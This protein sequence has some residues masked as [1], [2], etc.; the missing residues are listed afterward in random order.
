MRPNSVPAGR[1]LAKAGAAPK[2]SAVRSTAPSAT[3][4]SASSWSSVNKADAVAPTQ[5]R[6]NTAPALRS[7]RG[8]RGDHGASS[9][10]A[11]EKATAPA[12]S[13]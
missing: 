9:S 6:S 10:A 4:T 3:T 1:G 11:Q 12:R 2:L 7:Q 8:C 13:S 5:A